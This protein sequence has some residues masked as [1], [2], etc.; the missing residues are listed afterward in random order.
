M[1]SVNN[2]GYRTHQDVYRRRLKVQDPSEC[3]QEII[4]G[5]AHIMVF[6]RMWTLKSLFSG[7]VKTR[8]EDP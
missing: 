5:I 2:W 4:D 1:F 3:F 6:S 7:S 8:V